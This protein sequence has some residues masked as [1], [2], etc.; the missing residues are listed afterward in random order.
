MTESLYVHVV[1][2][3]AETVSKLVS[4]PQVDVNYNLNGKTPIMVVGSENGSDEEC[5]ELYDV[6]IQAG[7]LNYSKSDELWYD[8]F[9]SELFIDT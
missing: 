6:L 1:N 4:I 3:H 8:L 7:A 2:G 5:Y 9:S